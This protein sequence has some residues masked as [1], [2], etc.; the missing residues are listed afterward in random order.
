[1]NNR[2]FGLLLALGFVKMPPSSSPALRPGRMGIRR[3][4]NDVARKANTMCTNARFL[5]VTLAVLALNAPLVAHHSVAVNY[6]SSRSVTVKGVLTEIRWINPHSR[7][8]LEPDSP[9][10]GASTDLDRFHDLQASTE[11][12][13]TRL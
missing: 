3:I 7:F 5:V 1:M 13:H 9:R 11:C 2:L 4:G 6:D 10:A 12:G 8:R